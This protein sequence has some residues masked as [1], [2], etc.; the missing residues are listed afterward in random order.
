MSDERNRLRMKAALVDPFGPPRLDLEQRALADIG[1]RR[2]S[3]SNRLF[4]VAAFAI[5]MLVAVS[6]VLAGR[7]LRPTPGPATTPKPQVS[8]VLSQLEAR[9]LH[10]PALGPGGTCNQTDQVFKDVFYTQKQKSAPYSLLL[11]GTTGPIYGE[12]G[13]GLHGNHGSYFH[14]TWLS[15]AAYEGI[16]L[17]RGRKLDGPERIVFSGPLASGNLVTTETIDG[18]VTRFYDQL[19]IPQGPSNGSVWRTW[20]LW[21]GVPNGGCYAFQID[22]P[23]FE[24]TVVVDVAAS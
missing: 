2:M 7:V 8:V 3:Q 18:V 10:L 24:Q 19:V 21:Q 20:Q 23:A 17:V 14:V 13:S 9:P 22:G 16:A 6:V 5:F 4:A 1:G 15:D 11:Y 12:G